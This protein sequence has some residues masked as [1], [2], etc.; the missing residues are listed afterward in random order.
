[1]G[2]MKDSNCKYTKV[3]NDDIES[4]YTAIGVDAR[5]DNSYLLEDEKVRH[6]VKVLAPTKNKKE[7]C[8][9]KKHCCL[10]R[11]L[12]ICLCVILSFIGLA[13]GVGIFT[14]MKI[15]AVVDRWTTNHPYEGN[16]PITDVPPATVDVLFDEGKLFVDRILADQEPDDFVLTATD[17]NG[18]AGSSDY[19]RGNMYVDMHPNEVTAIESLPMEFLPGGR[20][21]FL[22]GKT[23]MVW[24]AEE[25]ILHA[26]M[27]SLDNDMM[28]QSYFDVRLLVGSEEGQGLS[29]LT[30]LSG[31]FLDWVVSQDFIDERTNL[32]EV[33]KHSCGHHRHRHGHHHDKHDDHGHHHHHGGHRHDNDHHHHHHH[34]DVKA[35]IIKVLSGIQGFELEEGQLV[36]RANSPEERNDPAHRMLLTTEEN[37]YVKQSALSTA[38]KLWQN[39]VRI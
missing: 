30:L 14:Y 13:L 29:S 38:F 37:S 27:V 22:V 34:R 12:K 7:N 32:L 10:K 31:Q 20:G 36:I 11:C 3:S 17:I 33:L 23:T 24:D 35:D 39:V 9:K 2:T 26:K 6:E 5:V 16:I 19:L 15:A 1:M 4:K 8:C 28:E 25:S 21:R 18:L